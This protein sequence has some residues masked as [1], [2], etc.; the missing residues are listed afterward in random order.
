MRLPLRVFVQELRMKGVWFIVR[1][2]SKNVSDAEMSLLWCREHVLICTVEF[3]R[4][5][6]IV[7]YAGRVTFCTQQN[8]TVL[9]KIASC[10]LTVHV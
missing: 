1:L 8:F 5:Q 3:L 7:S 6:E 4:H 2:T 9:T 10:I